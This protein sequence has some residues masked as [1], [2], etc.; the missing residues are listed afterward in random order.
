MR[1]WENARWNV[2]ALPVQCLVY[3]SVVQCSAGCYGVMYCGDVLWCIVLPYHLWFLSPPQT[4]NTSQSLNHFNRRLTPFHTHQLT[5]PPTALTYTPTQYSLPYHHTPTYYSPSYSYSF[6]SF[7]SLFSFFLR[8]VS[9]FLD[10][11]MTKSGR[12]KASRNATTV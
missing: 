6:T 11:V 4:N 8:R 9:H 2:T 3:R 7:F 12:D 5:P 10:D 1:Q